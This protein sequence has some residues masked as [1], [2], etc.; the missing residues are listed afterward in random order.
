MERAREYRRPPLSREELGRARDRAQHVIVLML[1]NRS[2]DHM[3]GFLDHTPHPKWEPL[4]PGDL[5][6]PYD[7]MQPA[8]A[9]GVQV[10]AEPVLRFDP[11]H[12]HASAMMQM[13][14]KPVGG[15]AMNGF[16]RAYAEKIAGREKVTT[17]QWLRIGALVVLLLAPLLTAASFNLARLGVNGGW[18]DYWPVAWKT[19]LAVVAAVLLLRLDAIPSMKWWWL[20]LGTIVVSGVL[21]HAG[22]AIG[23]WFDEPRGAISWNLS[24]VFT[25]A[26][27]VGYARHRYRQATPFPVDRLRQASARIMDCWNPADIPVLATLARDYAVC[28]RWHSSVPG[29][30]WPNRNF[31]HAATSSESVDIEIG[32]YEDPTIFELLTE[33]Y[34]DMPGPEP[35]RIYFHDTPQVAAFRKVWSEAPDGALRGAERL[36]DDIA[37]CD[38]PRYTFIEPQHTGTR[39]NSQHPGNNMDVTSTDFE[40]GERL[41][42]AIYNALVAKAALFRRTVF[43]ITYDEHGG[44]PDRWEPPRAVP[45]HGLFTKKRRRGL[46]RR[47]VGVFVSYDKT[48]FKFTHLGPRVPAVVVSP[49]IEPHEV[50]DTVYDH[51]SI[52]ATLRRLCE[53]EAEKL[54]QRD[55]GANDILHLLVGRTD[56]TTPAPIPGFTGVT[57]TPTLPVDTAA[58]AEM[59]PVV[60]A[61]TGSDLV[62]QL[63]SL[64]FMLHEQVATPEAR[65]RA[66]P[67]AVDGTEELAGPIPT[68][69][70]LRRYA[71]ST[72]NGNPDV[73]DI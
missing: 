26:L 67:T 32:F 35:W 9:V 11:P 66:T 14:E 71:D 68:A 43:V 48:P 47:I 63:E 3:L 55:D 25:G 64:N 15:F 40:D 6:N 33:T 31:A 73:E 60:R 41:I 49:W 50:D 52:V 2:F 27:L 65:A 44:F 5:P 42:A 16:V 39:S 51:S 7:P 1:E 4:Q 62:D 24:G 18:L 17:P 38:L 23:R 13:N 53:P 30:T 59:A 29:A 34:K 12:G 19:L 36:L 57:I 61:R 69:L 21:A 56:P 37:A 70:L 10:G 58:T 28:T 45:P 46:A 72:D 22:Q 54:T 8:D 20:T